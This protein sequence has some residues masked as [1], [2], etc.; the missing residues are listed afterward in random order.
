MAARR[1]QWLVLGAG[2]ARRGRSVPGLVQPRHG[3]SGPPHAGAASLLQR[4]LWRPISLAPDAAWRTH[5]R[6]FSSA[7]GEG[8]KAQIA[9]QGTRVREMKEALKR[10]GAPRDEDSHALQAEIDKLKALKEMRA[11]PGTGAGDAAVDGVAGEGDSEIAGPDDDGYRQQRWV[12]LEAFEARD[13]RLFP[14]TFRTSM[15]IPEFLDKYAELAPGSQATGTAPVCV[16]G[17]IHGVRRAGKGLV[18]LDLKGDGVRMQLMCDKK[19]FAGDWQELDTLIKRGDVVGATGIPTRNKRAELCVIPSHVELLAPCVRLL[20][21]EHFGL[22]DPD[23]RFRNRHVDLL[24]NA[25]VRKIFEGRSAVV[26]AIREYLDARS[27]LEVETPILASQVSLLNHVFNVCIY[28][29]HHPRRSG[30]SCQFTRLLPTAHCPPPH[31][32]HRLF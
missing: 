9:A 10:A 13:G 32:I 26:R 6:C 29:D 28:V 11:P 12:D 15:T 3:T 5:R 16:A 25:H 7:D 8:L 14:D 20:P 23:A 1:A 19:H 24:A 30:L 31:F 22:K 27:F 21:K 17:R 2:G 18:F 4:S